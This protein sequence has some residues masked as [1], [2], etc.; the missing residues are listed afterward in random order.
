[1][2]HFKHLQLWNSLLKYVSQ[3]GIYCFFSW[4]KRSENEEVWKMVPMLNSKSRQ[5]IRRVLCIFPRYA[6]SFGTMHHAFKLMRGVKAF[7][8]PQGILL[9]AA[10]L[11]KEWEVRFVDENVTPAMDEDFRWADVVL[12]SGMHVQR[13][14]ICATARRARR[15]GKLTVLGGASVSSCPEWYPD[16]DLLHIGELGDAT[17]RLIERL[18]Q[19]VALPNHQEVYTTVNRKP[20]T[21]FPMPAYH[22]IDLHKYFLGSVQF[23]SG[24]PYQCEFCDIPELY[25][26]QPRL[27]TPAQISAELDALLT[28][29]NP[30]AV[31]FV[32]DN[33][34]ANQKATIGLLEELVR[35]QKVRGYPLQFACE[36]SLNLAQSPHVLRLMREANFCTLFAGIETPDEQALQF[37][38][39]RQN[40]REPI[41]ESIRKLNEYGIEVVSGII[42]GLDTDTEQTG[43]HVKRFTQES[44]IP[45]L[46]INILHALPKT[47]LWRRLEADGRLVRSR[48]NR[49]SNVDFLLPYNKII[50]IW[51]DC[52]LTAFTPRAIYARFDYQLQYTYPN[53]L[54]LPVTRARLNFSNVH[55][56]LSILARIFWYVGIHSDYRRLFWKMTLKTLSQG[57][58]EECIHTA[59]VT[60]HMI[61]FARECVR[62]EAEKSFYS[63]KTRTAVVSGQR[64]SRK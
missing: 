41:L 30:G 6:Y 15:F 50:R 22:L 25:G 5:I 36:A 56:A 1:M 21:E 32:D 37:I 52:I 61:M 46:T 10:Y 9:V 27:K 64:A 3:K 4:S 17:D 58:I 19:S 48:P 28:R 11:P 62:D 12:L 49:E 57:K 13:E 8:P 44:G 31:Y 14:H 60:H 38:N 43:E 2:F 51:Q 40:L 42:L 33:F 55:R 54:S 7:M 47:P 53:R 29:G 24:C 18:R 35:W 26:R 63:E 23:S 34:I 39:K 59:M 16:L 45:M 20:M